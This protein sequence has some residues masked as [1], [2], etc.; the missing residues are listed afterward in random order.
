MLLR[1]KLPSDSELLYSKIFSSSSSS[2]SSSKN[3]KDLPN[4]QQLLLLPPLAVDTCSSDRLLIKEENSQQQNSNDN[5][6]PPKKPPRIFHYQSVQ[7]LIASPSNHSCCSPPTSFQHLQSQQHQQRLS[8]PTKMPSCTSS[9]PSS[10]QQKQHPQSSFSPNSGGSTSSPN[11][12]TGSVNGRPLRV[13]QPPPLATAFT[14]PAPSTSFPV[15]SCNGNIFKDQKQ[16]H[17]PSSFNSKQKH[18]QLPTKNSISNSSNQRLG[19]LSYTELLELARNQQR[20]IEANEA[21]LDERRKAVALFGVARKTAGSEREQQ[22]NAQIL[23]SNIRSQIDRDEKELVRLSLYRREA[24]KLREYNN[25]QARELKQLENDYGNDEKELRKV[26]AKVDTLRGKLENLYMKRAAASD[27]EKRFLLNEMSSCSSPKKNVE[28]RSSSS[29][30]FQNERRPKASVS[31]F[32]KYEKGRDIPDCSGTTTINHSPSKNH[33]ISTNPTISGQGTAKIQW[34]REL[35]SNKQQYNNIQQQTSPTHS[36]IN[37]STGGLLPPAVDKISLRRNSINQAKRNSLVSEGGD[38][39]VQALLLAELRRGRSHISFGRS[40]DSSQ[41][42]DEFRTTTRRGEREGKLVFEETE[43]SSSQ[44]KLENRFKSNEISKLTEK[45]TDKE[46]NKPK[47]S[48]ENQQN[49]LTFLQQQKIISPKT[50]PKRTPLP[51]EN[52]LDAFNK[53]FNKQEPRGREESEEKEENEDFEE[54][55]LRNEYQKDY[56]DK[57]E[58]IP[59][60]VIEVNNEEEKGEESREFEEGDHGEDKNKEREEENNYKT[61]FERINLRLDEDL[62][63]KEEEN[64]EEKEEEMEEEVHDEELPKTTITTVSPPLSDS[65]TVSSSELEREGILALFD[66]SWHKNI[67]STGNKGIL[68]ER[69]QNGVLLNTNTRLEPKKQTNRVKIDLVILFLD[70]AYEGQYEMLV[71]LASQIDDISVSNSEGLTALHYAICASNHDIVQFLVENGADVNALD[72]DGWTPLHCAASCGNLPMI[73]LLIEYGACPIATTISKSETVAQIFDDSN[74]NAAVGIEYMNFVE[75]C[76]GIVNDSK[77]YAA[78]SY[79][80]QRDDELSFEEGDELKVIR[81]CEYLEEEEENTKKEKTHLEEECD[82]HCWWLCEHTK[83]IFNKQKSGFVPRNYLALFPT[84]KHQNKFNVDFKLPKEIVFAEQNNLEIMRR[85]K[86]EEGENDEELNE[87]NEEE[88]EE[89]EEE[90]EEEE[91][92]CNNVL[93]INNTTTTKTTNSLGHQELSTYA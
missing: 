39:H 52:S 83:E 15:A 91:R 53:I 37:G 42:S 47:I 5:N 62:F 25:R 78:Y 31:P 75:E 51:P 90:G 80:P 27:S 20:Q 44:N 16:L 55:G 60:S 74:E 30:T 48:S 3:K 85:R 40:W 64:E 19:G 67:R 21:E 50:S 63:V 13:A 18:P 6:K 82:E 32:N 92:I 11:A 9:S 89:E 93:R 81:K 4:Q 71:K 2:S 35:P 58:S 56:N 49:Q 7:Q 38:E 43:C 28:G 29:N 69:Q 10:L 87:N 12:S 8:S 46:E 1:P 86:D 24:G 33:Q 26:F 22:Q 34:R 65:S 23:M 17:T 59:S 36:N 45:W 73:R 54:K 14:Q 66:D 68:R 77:V 79:S 76:M 70:V 61:V 72:V 41:L 88:G 84:L 57:V